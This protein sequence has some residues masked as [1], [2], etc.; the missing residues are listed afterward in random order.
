MAKLDE[1]QG[2]IEKIDEQLTKATG[3]IVILINDLKTQ[4]GSVTIPADA[5]VSLD[6]LTTLAQALDDIVPDKA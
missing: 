1:L 6:K 5:Q 4:L 3:E 2:I